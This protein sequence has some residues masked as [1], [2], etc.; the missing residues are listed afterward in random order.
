M[1]SEIEFMLKCKLQ[2]LHLSE[3]HLSPI[4]ISFN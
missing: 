3:I 4:L 1:D 2:P